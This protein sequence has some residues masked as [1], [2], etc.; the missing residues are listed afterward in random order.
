MKGASSSSGLPQLE[1]RTVHGYR[2]AFRRAGSGPAVLLLHGISD[3]SETWLPVLPGL[4]QHFTVV[5]PDMLGHGDSDKPR[6][7][8]SVAAFANGMR[9]LLDVLGIEKATVV[10]HSL[11][12]GVAAQLAYQYPER[13]ERLVLVSTGGVAREVAPV[14]RAATLPL[15]GAVMAPLRVPGSTLLVDAGVR[16]L[17]LMG[18][19]LALDRA[20]LARVLNSLRRTDAVGAFT[21]TLRAAVDW[22]GQL[23]TMLDRAYLTDDMP[24]MLVWGD[25]DGIIP[26]HHAHLAHEA[27]PHSRL[28]VYEGAG[29]FPHH[30][31]PERF[32]RELREFVEGTTAHRHAVHRRVELLR[33]G[34]QQGDQQDTAVLG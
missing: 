16:A 20:E 21:R 29:H 7:D 3:N 9:D 26:V 4:A 10:G 23:V 1:H 28:S 33:T 13:V 34:R 31:D 19:D 17:G 30:V 25:R 5:A 2:R 12:G 24:V 8:Y 18:H 22:R 27:L 15:A 14:L 32:V 6:G 11:G